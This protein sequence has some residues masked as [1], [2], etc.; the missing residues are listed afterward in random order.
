MLSPDLGLRLRTEPA[1]AS[2]QLPRR[3][4]GERPSNVERA[5]TPEQPGQH[6]DQHNLKDQPEERRR[7]RSVRWSCHCRI[8]ADHAGAEKPTEKPPTMPGRFNNPPSKHA[9]V[10]CPHA[11]RATCRRTARQKCCLLP[12]YLYMLPVIPP[13][14]QFARWKPTHVERQRYKIAQAAARNSISLLM[15]ASA[16]SARM[17]RLI[18]KAANIASETAHKQPAQRGPSSGLVQLKLSAPRPAGWLGAIE[19]SL[20]GTL[21]ARP[22]MSPDRRGR[23]PRLWGFICAEHSACGS[24]AERRTRSVSQLTVVCA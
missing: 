23:R 7:C 4:L 5:A 18:T 1:V 12:C 11:A 13:P 24:L 8:R 19:I 22:S 17:N 15:Y 21:A 2:G 9:P 14:H 20:A 3:H 6:Q 10:S 16:P